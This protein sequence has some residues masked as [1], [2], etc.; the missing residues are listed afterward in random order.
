[1]I[2]CSLARE[3]VVELDWGLTPIRLNGLD[4]EIQSIRGASERHGRCP[5]IA[6]SV[7]SASTPW[8]SR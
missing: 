8:P 4:A 5:P 7:R 6:R 2:E 3:T 1:M